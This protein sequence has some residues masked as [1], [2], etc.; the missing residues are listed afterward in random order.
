[1]RPRNVSEFGKLSRGDS[2]DRGPVLVL[3]LVFVSFSGLIFI[4]KFNIKFQVAASKNVA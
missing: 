3:V 1:M 2:S 4:F